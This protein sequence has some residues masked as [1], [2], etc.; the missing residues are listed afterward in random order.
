MTGRKVEMMVWKLRRMGRVACCE[1][2]PMYALL[3]T[4][5]TG[6]LVTVATKVQSALAGDYRSEVS[7]CEIPVESRNF[8]GSRSG[9]D[10]FV[11][12]GG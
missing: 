8:A 4:S 5:Q 6:C 7:A 12:D 3:E 2:R 9:T 10:F 11:A 1:A